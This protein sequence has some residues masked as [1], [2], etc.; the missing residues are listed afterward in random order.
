M[1]SIS[2][3]LTT[4]NSGCQLLEVINSIT[5]QHGIGID[6]SIELIVVDDC[7]TDNTVEILKN[8]NIEFFSTNKNSGGP[9]RGRN[10]ALKKCSGDFICIADHD[11]IWFPNKILELLKVSDFAPIITSGYT[12]FNIINN[13]KTKRVKIS[14]SS[15]FLY[16]KNKT[17]I[18]KL[19]KKK[20]GQQTYLGSI[21]FSS[22]FKN[23]FFEEEYGMVDFDWVL[24]LFHNNSSVEVC[25]SLYLRKVKS[26]NLSLD[27]S[28]RLNDYKCSMKTVSDFSDQYPSQVKISKK[29]INGSMGRYYYLMGDMKNARKYLMK[30]TF[31]LISILYL[32]TSFVGNKF[33]RK[34]FNIFG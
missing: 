1:I 4:Y 3:I 28:Y 27:E 13:Q 21:M 24:R 32:V 20:S 10:I 14:S 18:S 8:N 30:S 17:F 15:Y 11:D 34:Y 26:N 2:I 31:N 22:S 16:E 33:V 5:N 19:T 23:I 7:S 12:F 25:K 9:N 6:F 29:R